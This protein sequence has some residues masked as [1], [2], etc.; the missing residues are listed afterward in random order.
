MPFRWRDEDPG[1]PIAFGQCSNGEYDPEPV[2]PLRREMERLARDDIDRAVEATGVSRRAFLRSACAAAICLGAIDTTVARWL[3]LTPGRFYPLEPDARYQTD[4]ARDALGTPAFVFDVQGHLLEYDLDP[5]TRGDYFWGR[6][7][8]QARCEEEDDPRAC[9]S[10]N[11]FLEEV[12]IRS[13]TTMVALSGL[14]INPEGSP[15]SNET[16]EETRRLVLALSGDERVVV[17]ALVLPQTA[18]VASVAEEMERTI[19]E[20]RIAGWKTFTHFGGPWWLDDHDP[21]LPQVGHAFLDRVAALGAPIVFVHKGLSGRAKYGSP[22][23]VGPAAAAHPDVSIVVY[24]S[25]FEVAVREGPYRGTGGGVDRLVATLQE[26]GIGPGQNV[27]AELGSTWWHLLRRPTEAAHVLGKLLLAVGENN[28]LWGTDSI[29]YGSPQGQIE[30]F[31]AFE[32]PAD[33][34]ERFGYPALTDEIKG[35]ILGW[36]AA[37]LYDIEPITE[38]LGLTRE[39]LERARAEHLVPSRTWGPET[40]SAV[41]Q[42]REH[43]QGWP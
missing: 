23:D 41:R 31:R 16:M 25:G 10:T 34:Q 7:F 14:P 3:G 42:F 12:F 2:T 43:H 9:F 29:F 17:N 4:S 33:M 26:A 39:E 20:Q 40:R 32:I 35:K 18:S 6:Q 1:L 28:I 36:N 21:S 15:L 19:A 27:Y 37:R 24:H 8:P 5:S 38:P 22:A 30:A 11:H 13:D